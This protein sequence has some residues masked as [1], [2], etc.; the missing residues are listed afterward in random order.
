[1]PVSL[2]YIA[3]LD[4]VWV[5]CW[6][7][8][9]DSGA[10]TVVIIRNASQKSQH[11]AV[12]TQPIGNK[13]VQV[14]QSIWSLQTYFMFTALFQGNHSFFTEPILAWK[15]ENNI[16]LHHYAYGILFSKTIY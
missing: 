9:D 16:F 1:M 11:H 7:G 2:H 3:H 14:Y 8:E 15:Q 12:H 4:E 5:L 6:N 10:K 13:F